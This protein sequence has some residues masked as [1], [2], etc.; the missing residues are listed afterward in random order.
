[1]EE[2]KFALA[3]MCLLRGGYLGSM[4]ALLPNGIENRNN[5]GLSEGRKWN[6][7]FIK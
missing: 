2:I 3:G 1:M 6:E 5:E 4:N 7:K